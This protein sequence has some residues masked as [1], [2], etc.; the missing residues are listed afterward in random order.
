MKEITKNWSEN[1]WN[2]FFCTVIAIAF[3]IF[4]AVA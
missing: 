1:T 4:L 3:F 2:G